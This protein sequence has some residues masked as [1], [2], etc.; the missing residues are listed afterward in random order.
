[1]F[2]CLWLPCEKLKVLSAGKKCFNDSWFEFLRNL[3]KEKFR[4]ITYCLVEAHNRKPKKSWNFSGMVLIHSIVQTHGVPHFINFNFFSFRKQDNRLL[5]LIGTVTSKV[6]G[7]SSFCKIS[8]HSRN[9]NSKNTKIRHYTATLRILMVALLMMIHNTCFQTGIFHWQTDFLEYS[10]TSIAFN[11]LMVEM[12]WEK[13]LMP[14]EFSL[15]CS[16]N[17]V[18][19]KAKEISVN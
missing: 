3:S 13:R 1:M 8:L 7:L 19:S 12:L 14:S 17:L 11:T 9:I 4:S 10:H 18:L 2:C 5:L 16:I 6:C 15:C